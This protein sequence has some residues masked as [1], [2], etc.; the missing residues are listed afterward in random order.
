[1]VADADVTYDDSWNYTDI[2]WNG[3][4]AE[5]GC[6]HPF[7]HPLFSASAYI[8]MTVSVCYALL[9]K[10]EIAALPLFIAISFAILFSQ[11]HTSLYL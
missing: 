1:M 10:I 6:S 7:G 9:L 4:Q 3:I 8:Q 5:Q 11:F 2:L